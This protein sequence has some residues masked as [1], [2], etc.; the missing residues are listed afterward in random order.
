MFD[1]TKKQKETIWEQYLALFSAKQADPLYWSDKHCTR[2]LTNLMAGR[3]FSWQVVGITRKALEQ[4]SGQDFKRIPKDGIT[5][6]HIIP[7]KETTKKVMDLEKYLSLD[8]FFET[9][10]TNDK[11]V[12]CAKGENK[13]VL[14]EHMLFENPNNL[15]NCKDMVVGHRHRAQEIDFLKNLRYPEIKPNSNL[16]VKPITVLNSSPIQQLQLEF[17][18]RFKVYIDTEGIRLHVP[19]AK[20]RNYINVDLEYP[21]YILSMSINSQTR[22]LGVEIYI[23]HKAAKDKFRLLLEQKASIE[24]ELGFTLDWRILN[25]KKDCRIILFNPDCDIRDVISWPIYFK[26]L[27]IKG[28]KFSNVFNPA[29][30]DIERKH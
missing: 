19:K 4:Y 26:W 23:S 6:G 7:R 12:L 14:P 3:D 11:T 20:P 10:L 17:W 2:V 30:R 25:N 21:G 24:S 29:I 28:D 15:F 1:L 8:K 27:A 16:V 9:W 22:T 18:S 13:K 5:R